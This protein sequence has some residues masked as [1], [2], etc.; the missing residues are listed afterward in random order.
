M[1][2][3]EM[4]TSP[5]ENPS[6]SSFEA[7]S[8]E[9]E[10][11]LGIEG[12]NT[13]ESKA[14]WQ[15]VRPALPQILDAFYG[16]ITK[17][18]EL[19]EKL[20][21]VSKAV[22][23]LK[24]A[25]VDHWDHIFTNKLGRST[26]D[27]SKLVGEAHV[28]IG[29]EPKWYLAAYG[30]LL[31]DAIP[32]LAGAYPLQPGRLAAALQVLI[33]RIF[34]DMIVSYDAYETGVLQQQAE[35]N[36]QENQL[37]ALRSLAGTVSDIND[38][39]IGMASFSRNTKRARESGQAISAAATELVTSVEQIAA[40]S[41]SAAHQADATNEAVAHGLSA[42]D[43]VSQCMS[44][45]AATAKE[46]ANN[47]AD[48]QQASEQIG[49]FLSVVESIASQTNL[50][51]LNATIE[52]ARAG[53]AGRGFAVVA[54]EVKTLASQTARATE[55]ITQRIGALRAGMTTTQQAIA[56][57]SEAVT[58]GQKTIEG[59]NERMHTISSQIGEVSE[60]MKEISQILQQQKHSSQE[61]AESINGVADL[62]AENDRQL[63]E[64]S[65][66]LQQSNDR[67]AQD[68]Q[69]WFNDSSNRS[70]CEMA[71]IDHVLFKKRVI[72]TVI[73]RDDW[74]AG[75]V[76]DHHACRFGKW[77]ASIDSEAVRRHPAYKAIQD[78][79]QRVHL[80]ARAA[81]ESHAAGNAQETAAHLHDLDK[82]SRDVLTALA[83]LSQMF[84]AGG[85][86]DDR[87]KPSSAHEHGK[88]C[89]HATTAP[90]RAAAG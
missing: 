9:I 76:P 7:L 5:A 16:A 6:S 53:E 75:D 66:T 65:T 20:G 18:K 74:S 3:A 15:K 55:D 49:E 87:R 88:G 17:N 30:R 61:I 63:V 51:A 43:D 29:L 37:T 39:A 45:I 46:S 82:A 60:R 72:D 34:V 48:L 42:M 79:H 11:F 90:V 24:S 35:E 8:R 68:A 23:R 81:L 83:A 84:A 57:S 59:A 71:K 31:V 38:V 32:A 78:P 80:A 89:S 19:R 86:A 56:S 67:F 33:G 28:R 77:Y 62:A 22:P 73:G 12:R 21:D 50:L 26:A 44:D 10:H 14:V 47:L 40:N 54:S 4:T 52:A 1:E 13:A 64:M 2:D 70:M 58:R 25:Q 69:K 36:R 27:R 41:D 85:V